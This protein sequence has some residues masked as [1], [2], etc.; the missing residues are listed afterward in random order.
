MCECPICGEFFSQDVIEVSFFLLPYSSHMQVHV[1]AQFPQNQQNGL[2]ALSQ[3][4]P[5][6][7]S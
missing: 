3:R 4:Q 6:E 5:Y 1:M 2:Q 7:Y